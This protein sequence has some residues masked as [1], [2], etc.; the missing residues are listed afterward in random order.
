MKPE[1]P[2]SR[3]VRPPRLKPAERAA[4]TLIELLLSLALIVLATALIG[5]LLQMFSR[6]FVSRGDDIRR[7]QLARA[8][9]NMMAEDIRSV[10][11]EQPYDGTVLEQQL[12][13]GGGTGGGEAGSGAAGTGLASDQAAT[14][15]GATDDAAAM[16]DELM[17]EYSLGIYGDQYSLR[18]DVSR[19]PRSDE[20][21]VQQ[22]TLIDSELND[23]PG[24]IKTVTYYVQ[25]G[26]NQGVSDDLAIFGDS[27]NTNG[28]VG[29]LVRRALDRGVASYAEEIGDIDRL[30]RSGDLVAPEVIAMELAYFDGLEGQWV[31]Q[32]NSEEQS[33]PWLIQISLAM[34]SATAADETS[35]LEPGTPISSLT[36]EDRRAYGIEIYELIV[37]IPGANL[38]AADA[39][40]ADA[41]AGM[42]SMGL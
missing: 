23:V 20:Y 14:D 24:D 2:N 4:F 35:A 18:V 15:M 37:A 5:A 7:V 9:L 34:Q 19:L 6:N 13:A 42:E 39:A 32:W 22:A 1:N 26:T 3:N 38:I 36:L 33:L 25:T 10:V 40:A 12:G 17:A 8:V 28:F 41:A 11:L 29:G 30:Q 21:F 16:D 27:A 31:Y